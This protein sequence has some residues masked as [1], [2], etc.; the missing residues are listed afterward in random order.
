MPDQP[1][2]TPDESRAHRFVR[3][4]LSRRSFLQR[5]AVASLG[6]ASLT[7]FLDACAS[8]NING[9]TPS[10]S[11]ALQIASPSNPV[12]W[13]INAD[14]PIIAAGQKPEQG[15]VLQLYN[16]ADYLDPNAIKSFEKKYA[17]YNV[18]VQ[19]STF[20][21]TDEAMTKIRGGNVPYDMYWPSYDQISRLVN[22]KLIRPLQQSY[23]PNIANVWPSFHNPWYDQQWRYSVP[24][25]VYTTGVGW[26]GDQVKQDIGAL[27]NPY[28]SLWDPQYRGKTAVI[29]DWHTAMMLPLLKAGGT[30]MNVTDPAQIQGI[31]TQLTALQAATK[32]VV[33]ITMYNTI[34]TG[35]VGLSQ[36]WSGDMVNAVSY[37]P[38]G[39]SPK[40]LNYWFPPDGKGSVDNDLMV[41]LAKGKCPVLAHLFIDHM[42]DTPTSL[43]NFSFIG[44]Q[45]PQVSI[46][47]TQLVKDGYLP[48]NLASCTVLPEYFDV[49]F[50]LLEMSPSV[51]SLWLQQWQKFKAGG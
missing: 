50:R 25:T 51:T 28:A 27:P 46:N 36:F 40:V 48:A 21:D 31:G 42:L 39:Q 5:T 23:I 16:Y 12:L 34:A 44:Y 3:P 43:G 9:A 37:L 38:T 26:R 7:T 22:G 35:Q 1:V 10:G 18:K 49:G 41:V 11:A 30:D 15:G 17:A 6:A 13:P 45:P 4:P 2:H 32:P 19:V 8:S 29:D 24:Y 14:N 47:P 20:N 33:T